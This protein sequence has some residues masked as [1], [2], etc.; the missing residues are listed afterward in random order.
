MKAWQRLLMYDLEVKGICYEIRLIHDRRSH[1]LFD[2]HAAIAVLWTSARDRWLVRRK[3]QQ[4]VVEDIGGTTL[5]FLGRAV[6]VQ[7]G[8]TV[9][10]DSSLCFLIDDGLSPEIMSTSQSRERDEKPV[11]SALGVQLSCRKKEEEGGEE[12]RERKM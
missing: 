6:S 12:K 1:N 4:D 10:S 2:F 11:Y 8:D 5:T 3:A 7:T 9:R